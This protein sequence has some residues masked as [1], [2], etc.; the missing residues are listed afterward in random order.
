MTTLTR[1]DATVA[2]VLAG[3]SEDEAERL[4]ACFASPCGG[5]D[6]ECLLAHSRTIREESNA[7]RAA[8]VQNQAWLDAIG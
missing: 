8:L 2:L 4:A 5:D 6:I 1:S 3:Y 7:I